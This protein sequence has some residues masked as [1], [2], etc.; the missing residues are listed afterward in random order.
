VFGDNIADVEIGVGDI[1]VD[2]DHNHALRGD[3]RHVVAA[4]WQLR[5]WELR[6]DEP[7]EKIRSKIS[8]QVY[9]PYSRVSYEYGPRI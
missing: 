8:I 6:H 4:S 3:V 7:G 2:D 1:V 5:L 9:L